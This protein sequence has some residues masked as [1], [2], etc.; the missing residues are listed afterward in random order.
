MG[1]VGGSG[2]WQNFFV[3]NELKSPKN[4]MSF[5]CFIHIFGVGGGGGVRPKY[6]Y[7]HIFF[8]FFL[9]PYL[10]TFCV[11]K[12]VKAFWFLFCGILLCTFLSLWSFLVRISSY[13]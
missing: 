5:F 6:G 8:A 7:I 10:T 2:G 4:N 3:P 13:L 9:N 11:S 12:G 1:P